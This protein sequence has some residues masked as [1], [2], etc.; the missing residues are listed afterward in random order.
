MGTPKLLRKPSSPLAVV[1]AA[2]LSALPLTSAAETPI[3]IPDA[4]IR[5][6]ATEATLKENTASI[7]VYCPVKSA[8]LS[9]DQNE[10]GWLPYASDLEPGSHYLEVTVPGYHSLGTQFI[11]Q[12][13]TLYT[14]E[15]APT[16]I[17]GSLDIEVEPKDATILADGAPIAAGLSE[18][19][20]GHHRLVVRRFGYAEQSSDVLVAEK[21]TSPVAVRLEKAP[22]A[23]EGLGFS[24]NVF[25]PRNAGSA[26]K[27]SLDFVASS[28]G[29]ASVEIL[30]PDGALVASLEYPSIED[31]N[32]SR[33][34]NGLGPDGKALPDGLYKAELVAS[35]AEAGEPIKAQ[36]QVEIDSTLVISAFGTASAL[37]GLLY[38]PDPALES[39]GAI[40]V[41]AFCFAPL[42]GLSGS[43][44]D[45]AFGLS[46]AMSLGYAA[47]AIDAAAETAVGSGDLA[48]SALVG[49]FGDKTSGWS[50]AFFVK[51]GYSSSAAPVMPGARSGIEASVPFAARLGG[52][53]GADLRVALSPGARADFSSASPA[54][55]GLSRAAL[56]LE[57]GSFRAGL[58]GELPWGFAGGFAPLWPA[59]AALEGRLMLGSTPFVAAAYAATELEPGEASFEIGLGLGLQF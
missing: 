1:L 30:G 31:W 58:S 43:L 25:N 8:R 54:Y 40:A 22:F 35:P 23:I 13:K 41:E 51:G 26:G 45:L 57:G 46:A 32:Q 4:R 21:V 38:M 3:V 37:P 50:G 10:V 12:E 29:S 19:P 5:I 39:A 2:I 34:W 9:I 36:A 42:G 16:R 14:I 27:V 49:L 44:G 56:W 7:Q 17:A 20:V 15:F 59:K 55:L 33:D 18:F 53:A 47:F 52:I 24:K 6:T 28:Y 48:A 11:F